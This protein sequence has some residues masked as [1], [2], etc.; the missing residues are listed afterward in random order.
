[1]ASSA[2]VPWV[3]LKFGGT[4]VSSLGNWRNIATVV[5]ARL[6]A[7]TRVLIVHSAVSGVT[8]RLD[9]LLQAALHSAQDSVLDAI[10][11]RHHALSAELGIGVSEQLARYFAELRQ[12]AAGV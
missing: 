8:D 3:M 10:E 12:L 7:G 1:M 4:S 2:Q 11:Q 5:R 9:A 6:A